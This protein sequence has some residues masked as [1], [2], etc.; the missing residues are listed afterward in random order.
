MKNAKTY[1]Q[2]GP[3]VE[4][5]IEKFDLWKEDL[6]RAMRSVMLTEQEHWTTINRLIG[7]RMDD[8]IYQTVAM[9]FPTDR[10]ALAALNPRELLW[11]IEARLVTADQLEYK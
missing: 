7:T 10:E 6:L 8:D 4:A 5:G 9:F 1:L 3:L 2:Q 11:Q